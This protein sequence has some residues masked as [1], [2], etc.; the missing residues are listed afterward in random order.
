MKGQMV[1]FIVFVLM[2]ASGVEAGQWWENVNFK[3]DFRHR[4]EFIRDESKEDVSDRNRWRIRL[5]FSLSG[6]ISE[7]WSVHTR[8]ATG[9]DDPVSA[10]QTLDGGFS[11]KGFHLDRAYFAFHPQAMKCL[12]L[13]GGKIE[14]PFLVMDKTEL[15]WDGDLNPEGMAL[16]LNRSVSENVNMMINGAFFYVEE[17]KESDDTWMVGLQ[18]AVDASPSEKTKLVLGGGYYDYRNLEGMEGMYDPGEFFGNDSRAHQHVDGE[19]TTTVNLY[20]FDYD[21]LEG[22]AKF[23]VKQEEV[24][25]QIYG[26]YVQNIQA[27]SLDKGWLIG[28]SMTYGDGKGHFKVRANWRELERNAV[29]GAFTDSDFRGGGTDGKGLEANVEYGLSD[30]VN[31]GI[32]Y[33]MNSKGVEEDL[34]YNRAQ[35]DLKVKF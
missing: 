29:V 23:G 8:F 1:A 21:L 28:G 31:L 32:S 19:D 13:T 2:L 10:N 9:S 33:F 35:A 15:I 14:R 20:S 5:R 26:N 25:F 6:E 18:A 11:T 27:D 3:G 16:S 7:D 24:S 17:R 34:E 22:F 4:H 30:K 12:K